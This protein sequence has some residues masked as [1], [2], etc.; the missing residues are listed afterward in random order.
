MPLVRSIDNELITWNYD[1]LYV[2]AM[3]GRLEIPLREAEKRYANSALVFAPIRSVEYSDVLSGFAYSPPLYF[4]LARRLDGKSSV[5]ISSLGKD[6]SSKM[7][8]DLPGRTGFKPYGPE[9]SFMLNME[10]TAILREINDYG[11]AKKLAEVEKL[12]AEKVFNAALCADHL[13]RDWKF[14][15]EKSAIIAVGRFGLKEKLILR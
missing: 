8:A 1:G 11:I 4:T 6:A 9:P 13:E 15:R 2:L 3:Q 12:D 5:V 10:R 7:L 14:P